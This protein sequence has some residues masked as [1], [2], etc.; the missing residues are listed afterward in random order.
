MAVEEARGGLAAPSLPL[1]VAPMTEAAFRKGAL[2]G[3][4]LRAAGVGVEVHAPAKM[5]RLMELANKA[6]AR[7]ALLIGDDE[8]AAGRYGLKDMA[9]GEQRAVAEE[10][11][12][13][14]I[15]G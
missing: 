12:L 1:F 2:I 3:R 10:E 6:G 13:G 11:L 8:L 5:K 7:Y 9:S 4:A 15:N 14:I